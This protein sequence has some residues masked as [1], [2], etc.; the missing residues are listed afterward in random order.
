MET[1]GD[2]FFV[3]WTCVVL[4]AWAGFALIDG[5]NCSSGSGLICFG[6]GELLALLALPAFGVWVAGLLVAWIVWI[7]TRVIRSCRGRKAE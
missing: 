4:I 7:T 6:T 3:T 2:W 1:K 5:G